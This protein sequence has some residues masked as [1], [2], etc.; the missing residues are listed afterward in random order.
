V[1]NSSI[2][3]E[4]AFYA[5]FSNADIDA[6]AAIWMPGSDAICVHPGGPRLCGLDA[7]RQSWSLI[8]SD[9]MPRQFELRGRLI[10][11]SGD[12]RIHTLEENISVPGTEFVAPPVLATNIYQKHRDGWLMVLHHASV[13][14]E[15]VADTKDTDKPR[16]SSQVL[17]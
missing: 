14:P 9:S 16:H 4:A 6:M 8:L 11:G 5:A 13:S 2:D 15:S 7:I 17:H 10:I 1:F 3:A 12:C